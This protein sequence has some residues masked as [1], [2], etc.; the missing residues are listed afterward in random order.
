MAY[1][2]SWQVSVLGAFPL[3]P[4]LGRRTIQVTTTGP[5]LARANYKVELRSSDHE[6][7]ETV[8]HRNT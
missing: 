6:A 7:R 8:L 3:A 5:L 1:Y 4:L 2:T